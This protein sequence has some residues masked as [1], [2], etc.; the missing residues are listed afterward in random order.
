MKSEPHDE[1]MGFK[2][3]QIPQHEDD[4][5]RYGYEVKLPTDEQWHEIDSYT[6]RWNRQDALEGLV[7]LLRRVMNEQMEKCNRLTAKRDKAMRELEEA[8]G[9]I[10][11][12]ESKW[13]AAVEMA[14]RAQVELEKATIDIPDGEWVAYEEYK[15]IHD[16]ASRLL[17]A[18]NKRIP[19]GCFTLIGSEYYRLQNAIYGK[20]DAK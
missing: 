2:L 17:V 18:I 1:F 19:I 10:I 11:G 7:W 20:E 13:K 3:R 15:K 9:I 8:D 4:C 12:W 14:A 6:L 5:A 16:A